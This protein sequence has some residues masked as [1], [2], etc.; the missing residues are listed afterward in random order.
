MAFA[1]PALELIEASINL[2]KESLQGSE[3]SNNTHILS[4][5]GPSLHR[6]GEDI[7]LVLK[8]EVLR[9]PDSCVSIQSEGSSSY[10]R[11]RSRRSDESK[12][13]CSIVGYEIAAGAELMVA[14]GRSK[15]S[16]EID[17]PELFTYLK[18][19]EANQLFEGHLPDLIPLDYIEEIYIPKNL[20]ALLSPAAQISARSIFR[21][22][23]HQTPHDINPHYSGSGASSVSDKGRSEY[24][25]YIIDQLNKK[26]IENMGRPM[27]LRGT[28]ITLPPSD[29]QKSVCLP[30]TIT[31][32]FDHY[33][34]NSKSDSISEDVFIYWQ[35]MSGD[36]MLTLSS[37]SLNSCADSSDNQCLICYIAE[38]PST[39]TSGYHELSSYLHF[40]DPQQHA[41]I[42][43]KRSF[44][45]TCQ[46]LSSWM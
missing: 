8:H 5:L 45:G 37:R 31:R 14:A 2:P 24:Q 33:R 19:T 28:V 39:A 46:R 36:M 29:F 7:I 12:L 25:N 21:D 3:Y 16:I 1:I 17:L 11:D 22:S 9:H 40:G 10:G 30:F 35:A 38:T 23:L 41:T 13:H 34:Q 26:L 44:L 4:V 42:M 15:R 27:K 20:F 18:K 43:K 6:H 32:I